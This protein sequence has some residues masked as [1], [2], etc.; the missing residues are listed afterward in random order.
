MGWTLKGLAG[1]QAWGAEH[2]ERKPTAGGSVAGALDGRGA[3]GGQTL[4]WP[5]ISGQ[6]EGAGAVWMERRGL[7]LRHLKRRSAQDPRLLKGSMYGFEGLRC[8]LE[9]GL[10][11]PMREDARLKRGANPGKAPA[12]PPPGLR[13]IITA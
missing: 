7:C 1:R 8:W 2:P 6:V 10:Q 5:L 11:R 13:H 4:P 12:P 3:G 9:L